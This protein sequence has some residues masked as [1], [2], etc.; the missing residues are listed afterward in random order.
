MVTDFLK[1][2]RPLMRGVRVDIRGGQASEFIKNRMVR[3]ML[4]GL[5]S[6]T[7]EIVVGKPID[8]TCTEATQLFLEDEMLVHLFVFWV[9]DMQTTKS[10][11]LRDRLDMAETMVAACGPVIQ[12][13]QHEL[14]HSKEELDKYAKKVVTE[15][16][17]PGVVLREPFGTFGTWD[18]TIPAE[19]LGLALQ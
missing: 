12:Y 19:G 8:P 14:I 5:P 10:F 9:Y 3:D 17:F 11:S 13:V 1:L 18:E 2:A 6:F 4:G 7:G 15:N 16:H